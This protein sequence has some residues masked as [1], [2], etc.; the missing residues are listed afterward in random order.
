MDLYSNMSGD[1]GVY[2]YDSGSDF[3]TVFFTSGKQYTYTYK[4]AGTSNV[5]QMKNLARAGSGLNS[6]IN[7]NC[8]NDYE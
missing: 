3:I 8:K 5:E 2:A 6:F 7:K 4:S 1:S